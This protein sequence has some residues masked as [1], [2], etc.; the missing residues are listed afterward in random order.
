MTVNWM[1][2]A[3]KP[4][5]KLLMKNQSTYPDTLL[6]NAW[7]ASSRHPTKSSW[8]S[9]R[10]MPGKNSRSLKRS[11]IS[12]LLKVS[13]T[14]ARNPIRSKNLP[15]SK[16]DRLLVLLNW[17]PRT[18]AIHGCQLQANR[19]PNLQRP[20]SNSNQT[21]IVCIR[22]RRKTSRLI[23]QPTIKTL[24]SNTRTNQHPSKSKAN[25][26]EYHQAQASMR[27]A[28]Y[29]TQTQCWTH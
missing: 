21:T 3:P 1:T 25:H 16:M 18:I 12:S 26:S 6:S 19:N 20:A 23:R 28:T 13:V 22:T 29:Q 4:A 2:I 7:S 9:I 27:T 8:R 10:I 11:L 5:W 24:Q 14:W 15:A 17:C